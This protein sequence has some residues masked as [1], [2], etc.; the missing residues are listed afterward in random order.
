MK[1][2]KDLVVGD[3]VLYSEDICEANT[4]KV[5]IEVTAETI[6]IDNGIAFCRLD[7]C[8]KGGLYSGKRIVAATSDMIKSIIERSHRRFLIQEIKF[9]NWENTSIEILDKITEIL[10]K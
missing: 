4:I 6:V 8:V 7:G 1:E 5:I 3:R 9:Y 10:R 2:L